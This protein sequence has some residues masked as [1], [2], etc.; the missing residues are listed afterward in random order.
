MEGVIRKISSDQVAIV[1]ALPPS[2]TEL[3]TYQSGQLYLPYIQRNTVE[4]EII[5]I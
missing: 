5:E 1:A 2:I 3:H 4:A